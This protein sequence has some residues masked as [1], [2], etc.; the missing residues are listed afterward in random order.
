VEQIGRLLASGRDADIFEFGPDLVLRRSRAG[1]SLEAE[2]RIMDYLRVHGYPVPAV[3]ELTDDGTSLIMER[4]HGPSMVDY[5]ARRP[6]MI[7]R[8]GHTLASLHQQLHE[9]PPPDFLPPV[10]IGQGEG[11]LHMDLHPLNVMIGTRGPVVID[12]T[13]AGRGDPSV[14]VALAYILMM[15]GQVP[16][17]R[18]EQAVVAV[19]RKILA[20]SFLSRFDRAPVRDRM[21]EVVDWKVLDPHMSP[22]EIRSMRQIA[23][24]TEGSDHR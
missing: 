10:P 22:Q 15:S 12:W 17:S 16:T 9:V 6:W 5:L 1:R 14:D 19:G 18:V 24:G 13:N 21:R 7:H 20:R 3:Q 11:F 8:L 23:E 4:I 2:A